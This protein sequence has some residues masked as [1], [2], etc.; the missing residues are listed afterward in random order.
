MPIEVARQIPFRYSSLQNILWWESTGRMSS[1]QIILLVQS[2][3]GGAK[4]MKE[5]AFDLITLPHPKGMPV[6]FVQIAGELMELQC[7]EPKK[8]GSWFINQKVSSSSKVYVAT[9]FDP[10]FLCLPYLERAG[11]KFCPLDQVVCTND[12]VGCSRL[13][14]TKSAQWKLDEITDVKDLG[15]DLIL[16]RFNESKTLDWL[17]GKVKR[18]AVHFMNQ[19]RQKMD[20][21]NVAFVS[22]F[23]SSIQAN[24]NSK[25]STTETQLSEPNSHD[26]KTAVQVISDYLSESMS[27]KLLK[28]FGLSASDLTD[29]KNLNSKRKTDWEADLEVLITIVLPC[30]LY[31]FSRI[32]PIAMLRML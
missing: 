22:S 12:V 27:E 10:R 30:V 16:F 19:R 7:I 13:P 29:T 18:T 28:V 4:I 11:T 26:I 31:L 6:V 2:G 9:K 15:D 5:A 3:D 1:N 32:R 8:R 24:V 14:L 17:S 23:Q 20:M 21:E 25:N